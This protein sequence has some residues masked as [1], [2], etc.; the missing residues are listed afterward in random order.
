MGNN[1]AISLKTPLPAKE[2]F[3]SLLEKGLRLSFKKLVKAKQQS[4][5]VLYFSENGKIIKIKAKDIKVK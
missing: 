5:S 3:T 1:K 2:D 4:N